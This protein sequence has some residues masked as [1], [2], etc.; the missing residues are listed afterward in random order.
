MAKLIYA[1]VAKHLLLVVF[2]FLLFSVFFGD[3][4]LELKA[5]TLSLSISSTF[6]E[7]F[8]R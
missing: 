6:S 7:G 5:F 4:G 1:L 3:T 2:F 8:L